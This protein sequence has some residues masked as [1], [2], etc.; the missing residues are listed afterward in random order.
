M[1]RKSN[2]FLK[3]TGILMIIGGGLGIIL[4]IVAILGLSLLIAII[5][6]DANAGLLMFSTVLLLV[7]AVI[8]LVAGI[9]GVAN[10][11]KPEKAMTCI[12]F[13]VLVALIAVLASVLRVVAGADFNVMNLIIGLVLPA[14][15]LIGALQNKKLAG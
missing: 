7:S 10:A 5:G 9:I 15:Y 2:M 1:E 14:L 8:Q 3:V 6:D 13:G 11:A 4:Y 12:V